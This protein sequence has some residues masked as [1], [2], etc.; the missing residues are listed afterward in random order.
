M[1]KG[2]L[3]KY[4]CYIYAFFTGC[5]LLAK[6]DIGITQQCR[7]GVTLKTFVDLRNKAIYFLPNKRSISLSLSSIYVGLP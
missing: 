3:R 2:N 7:H 4:L 1:L 6:N 5:L